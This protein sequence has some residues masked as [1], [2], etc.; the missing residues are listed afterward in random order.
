MV[1]ITY[2][3]IDMVLRFYGYFKIYF[4]KPIFTAKLDVRAWLFGHMLFWVSHVHVF[5]IWTCSMQLSM[6]H[7]ERRS[8]NALITIIG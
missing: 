4:L 3:Y 8:R 5:C 7:M 6:F 2:V 1:G